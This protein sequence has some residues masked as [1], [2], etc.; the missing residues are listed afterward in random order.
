MNLTN[1]LQDFAEDVGIP[2]LIHSDLAA[3]VEGRHTEFQK[4]VRHL[5]TKTKYI[6][7]GRLNQNHAAEREIGELKKR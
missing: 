1:S 7:S 6:E 3:A 4:L 5:R 2:S